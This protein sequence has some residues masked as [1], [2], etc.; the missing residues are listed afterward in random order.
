MSI[1][2][3]E[4]LPIEF[5]ECKCCHISYEYVSAYYELAEDDICIFCVNGEET[6]FRH[7][8]FV[9]LEDYIEETPKNLED[10]FAQI[11]QPNEEKEKQELVETEESNLR[12]KKKRRK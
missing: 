2:P 3:R 11:D 9:T 5:R 1:K 7:L 6:P 8:E 4:N 10:C 12:R